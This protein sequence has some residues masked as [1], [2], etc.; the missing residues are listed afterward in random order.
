MEFLETHTV[1]GINDMKGIWSNDSNVIEHDE[2]DET[3]DSEDEKKEESKEEKRIA[4][5]VV[6][7]LEVR[8]MII[9]INV[10]YRLLGIDIQ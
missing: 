8:L 7:D 3:R 10:V 5:K 6:S 2:D 1:H 4:N 9:P